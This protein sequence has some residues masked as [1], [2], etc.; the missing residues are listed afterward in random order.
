MAMAEG[1]YR[2]RLK[3]HVMSES[4]N[5]N[6]QIAIQ[7][8]VIGVYG[9]NGEYSQ[10]APFERTMFLTIT[11]KTVDWIMETLRAI[12]FMG[13]SFTELDTQQPNHHSFAGVEVD[14]WCKHDEYDGKTREKWNISRGAGASLPKPSDRSSLRKLDALYGSYLQKPIA[15]PPPPLPTSIELENDNVPF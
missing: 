6:P 3:E 7:F 10:H 2:I 9:P 1:K 13:K 4:K 12:G 14:A 15:V 8:D 11:D 5:G